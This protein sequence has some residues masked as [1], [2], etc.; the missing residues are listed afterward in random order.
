MSNFAMCSLKHTARPSFVNA[1]KFSNIHQLKTHHS[2]RAVRFTPFAS[3]SSNQNSA[4]T[5]N[6]FSPAKINI[7]LRIVRR[8]EDGFHDLASL[9]HVIDL[10]DDMTFSLLPAGSTSDQLTCN[11]P[12]VP[13]DESNLV[14]KALNLFR[15]KTGATEHFNVDLFKRVPHGAGMGGGSGNAATTLWAANEMCGRPATA[16]Q[17]LEWSGEIGSD[18]SVFFSS[19]AA[20]CTGR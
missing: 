7:F 16:E 11:F 8:R 6:L 17:L 14:I 2:A 4:S 1:P 15:R 13:T 3:A 9:F 12:D 10:G 5:L 20:Y 18:I 19:G